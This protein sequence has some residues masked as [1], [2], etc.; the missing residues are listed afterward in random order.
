MASIVRRL[1]ADPER[2]RPSSARSSW[3]G[4]CTERL[5]SND[6]TRVIVSADRRCR[7][8]RGGVIRRHA[9]HVRLRASEV[10]HR[11]RCRAGRVRGSRRRP[12]RRSRRSC[13]R[14]SCRDSRS[15]LHG[16]RR[17]AR[18]RGGRSSR[19]LP[20]SWRCR[21]DKRRSRKLVGSNVRRGN[22]GIAIEVLRGDPGQ[23]GARVGGCMRGAARLNVEIS[24]RGVD[25]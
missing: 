21:F 10:A 13:C 20:Y 5:A 3:N 17:R 12:S 14:G 19:R 1:D 18:S 9:L 7:G 16:S 11:F 6:S 15:C 23:I 8:A 25:E 22:A 24:R 4:T 2:S